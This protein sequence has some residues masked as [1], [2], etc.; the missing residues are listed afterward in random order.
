[1]GPPPKRQSDAAFDRSWQPS[2][3]NGRWP[4]FQATTFIDLHRRYARFHYDH[5]RHDS[6]RNRRVTNWWRRTWDGAISRQVSTSVSFEDPPFGVAEWVAFS[7]SLDYGLSARAA[8]QDNLILHF[9]EDLQLTRDSWSGVL[10][11]VRTSSH[12]GLHPS[13]VPPRSCWLNEPAI[14]AEAPVLGFP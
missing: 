7:P 2:H 5:Q 6:V 14:Q 1:M 12:A 13:L 8:A 11:Q 9:E 4:H 10:N 3:A